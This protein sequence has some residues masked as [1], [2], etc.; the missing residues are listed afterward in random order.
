MNKGD[1]VEPNHR[2]RLVARQIRHKGVEGIFAGTPPLEAVRTVISL[3]ATGMGNDWEITWKAN[4][5]ERTQILP[6]DISRAYFCAKTDED[7]QTYVELPAEHPQHGGKVG[8]LR[9]HMCGTLGAADGWQEEYSCTLVAMGF[10]QGLSNPCI[11]RHPEWKVACAVHGGCFTITGPADKLVT[12]E[13]LLRQRYELK[14]GGRLGPGGKDDKEGMVLNRIVRWCL[15]SVECEADPRQA[16]KLVHEI[17]LEGAKPAVTPGTK[18]THEQIERDK[19]PEEG[20]ERLFR[21]SAARANYLS[22]DRM[23]AMYASKEICRFMSKPTEHS[24][25]S[26][27]RLGRYLEGKK[28]LVYTYPKQEVEKID[29]YTGTDWAGCARTRKSTSGGCTMLGSHMIKG[30]SSTQPNQALSSGEAEY[31]GMV[32]GA[33]IGLGHRALARDLGINLSIRM[34]VG[35]SAAIGVATRQGVGKIRHL[36]TKTLWVQQAVRT[37]RL[38]VRKVEGTE[39]PADLCTKHIPSASKL[40]RLVSLFGGEFRGGRAESAPQ[41]RRDRLTQE[42][43][44]DVYSVEIK[45]GECVYP[46]ALPHHTPISDEFFPGMIVESVGDEIEELQDTCELLGNDIAKYII[47]QP[48]DHGRKR[49]L[50]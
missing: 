31:Y 1:D 38:E 42:K 20:K 41:M 49:K 47:E 14:V 12:V 30:W 22:A 8:L 25:V 23:D 46:V 39:D 28:R 44:S 26:I 48:E 19:E 13:N 50:T 35:S 4:C 16:E 10:K 40:E 9:Q 6:I 45:T 11:F 24:I 32:K 27:K 7:M 3:A 5:P 36:D 43:L 29:I 37:G 21:A 15:D 33:S 17:G 2:P 18:P 34:W